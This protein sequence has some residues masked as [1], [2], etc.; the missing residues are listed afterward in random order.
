MIIPPVTIAYAKTRWQG[1]SGTKSL[2][3][4]LESVIGNVSRTVKHFSICASV[5]NVPN[6]YRHNKRAD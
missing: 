1:N 2:I 6:K 3:I 4:G 5:V